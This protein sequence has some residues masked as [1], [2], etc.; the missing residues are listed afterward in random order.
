MSCPVGRP[1][2]SK[3]MADSRGSRAS[4]G[5][6]RDKTVPHYWWRPSSYRREAER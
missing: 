3:T 5:P 4:M 1:V 2:V 6:A